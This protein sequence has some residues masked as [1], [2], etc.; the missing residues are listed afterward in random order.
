[1]K[2]SYEIVLSWYNWDWKYIRV[3]PNNPCPIHGTWGLEIH[4]CNNGYEKGF[5]FDKRVVY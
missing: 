1:M 4:P 5:I 3:F 2:K